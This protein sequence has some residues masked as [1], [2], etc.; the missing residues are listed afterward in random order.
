MMWNCT[1]IALTVDVDD[2]TNGA[3]YVGDETVGVLP[4]V[5]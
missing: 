5:V 3:E 2:T 1:A 4:S